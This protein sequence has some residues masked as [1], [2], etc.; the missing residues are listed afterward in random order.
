MSQPDQAAPS[1]GHD[2][3]QRGWDRRAGEEAAVRI[4]VAGGTG[5]TG[6]LV[7]DGLAAAGHET[8]VLS[9]SRGADLMT[10]AGVA[11]ALAGVD[12]VVDVTNAPGATRD[13]SVGYFGPATRTL[14]AAEREAGVGHHVALSIVGIDLVPRFG[15]YQGK[16]LQ[17]RLIRDGGVP[18]TVL[19]ATQFHEFAEM[20]LGLAYGPVTPVP[21]MRSQP[22]AVREVAD[23]L[24]ELAVGAPA[25]LAPDFGGPEVGWMPD[26]SR[27]VARA[28]GRRRY[29]LP[30]WIPGAT[31][32]GLAGGALLPAGNGPRG[33]QTF[34][35][36]LAERVAGRRGTAITP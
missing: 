14:L 1:D 10:G 23:R 15:Y 9:R 12:T 25:G 13:A 33:T 35:K 34:E 3:E 24:V 28:L 2:I 29:V 21:R 19:R 5:K 17:E 6:R 36:W 20:L 4:A 31:G 30:L 32:R 27:R 7:V 26:L 8:V 16:V 18:W 11:A 22:V